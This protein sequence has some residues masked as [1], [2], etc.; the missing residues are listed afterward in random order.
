MALS[1]ILPAKKKHGKTHPPQPQQPTA[2]P[3]QLLDAHAAA[4]FLGLTPTT[5]GR[6]RMEKIG[7]NYLKMGGTRVRY[8]MDQLLDFVQA[9][10]VS[11]SS[12]VA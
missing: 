6:W 10:A 3:I 5:L 2:V 9:Q 12:D 1:A 11:T 4:E 7:P 8:R